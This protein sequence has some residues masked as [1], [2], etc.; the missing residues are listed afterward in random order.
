[1][2]LWYRLDPSCFTW[3]RLKQALLEARGRRGSS[4]SIDGSLLGY[5]ENPSQKSKHGTLSSVESIVQKDALT[6][7][8]EIKSL[9]KKFCFLIKDFREQLDSDQKKTIADVQ[10]TLLSLPQNVH[11]IYSPILDKMLDS[12]EKCKSFRAFF[13]KMNDCWNFIDYDLLKPFIEEHGNA[14]L[15]SAMNTYLEEL[16]QFCQSTTVY[17]LITIWKPKYPKSYTS[18]S[19]EEDRKLFMSRLDRDPKTYTVQQL[20]HFRRDTIEFVRP[21]LTCAMILC[22]IRPGSLTLLWLVAEKD[23]SVFSSSI[24]ARVNT[25]HSEFVDQHGIVFLSLDDYILYPVE[26]VR[27]S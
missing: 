4:T 6:I 12:L 15:K 8:N 17:Q 10:D 18:F 16:N 11:A 25:I 7:E 3:T 1:M 27:S 2:E 21:L 9:H 22:D 26:E 24:S 20:D 23:V 19:Q 5:S 14:D 13:F